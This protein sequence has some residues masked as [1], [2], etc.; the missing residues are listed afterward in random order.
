[1]FPLLNLPQLSE[2]VKSRADYRWLSALDSTRWLEH[3][4]LVLNGA[5]KVLPAW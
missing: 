2:V 1:L 5:V 4:R 3:V